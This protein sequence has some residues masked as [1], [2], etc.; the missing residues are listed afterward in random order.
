M[1]KRT[2][3]LLLSFA[4][5]ICGLPMALSG[6]C[7]DQNQ[8]LDFGG[9]S[10]SVEISKA[11]DADN[12]GYS[13]DLELYSPSGGSFTFKALAL[14][15]K[16]IG[17]KI[18]ESQIDISMYGSSIEPGTS[19]EVEI[20]IAALTT[21]GNY[22]GKF[23]IY[24]ID[25]Q[26]TSD[27]KTPICTWEVPIAVRLFEQAKVAIKNTGA[28][29]VN[30]VPK[31]WLNF[32]LPTSIKGEGFTVNVKNEGM[33][34]VE[35]EDYSLFLQG[36]Q[37]SNSLGDEQLYLDTAE[38]VTKILPGRT[39]KLAF[40]FNKKSKVEIDTYSGDVNLH[41]K[42]RG[43]TI[44]T[45]V[46]INRR[47]GVAWALFALFLGIF[48][49][50][51]IKDV[52]KEESQEQIRLIEQFIPMR[53][54]VANI[55]DK[56]AKSKLLVQLRDLESQIN[57]VG[58]NADA[59]AKV[60]TQLPVLSKRVNQIVEWEGLWFRV[61]ENMKNANVKSSSAI[62][63]NMLEEINQVR[64]LILAGKDEEVKVGLG[65][66]QSLMGA[67]QAK[68]TKS[69]SLSPIEEGG[70][71][72]A[73]PKESPGILLSIE[74]L[75]MSIDDKIKE[76]GSAAAPSKPTFWQKVEDFF[77][78][79]MNFLTG[80]RVNARVRYALFRPLAMLVAFTVLLLMGFQ[81]I[82]VNGAAD[83]GVAGIYDY[84]K[85]FLWGVVS[86]VFSR[87]FLGTGQMDV[88]KG[89]APS[90]GA[91]VNADSSDD[92]APEGF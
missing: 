24:Q 58:N 36:S 61:E 32:I 16:D 91:N 66:V 39:E 86:D 44:S 79:A 85:L 73:P 83:F 30:T 26:D 1:I 90:F 43:E 47:M 67:I 13:Y 81:E 12:S 64:D 11:W 65:K 69:R 21:P 41:L 55:E 34:T 50:R 89:A 22:E 35:I 82:Y 9:K 63:G 57:Q 71:A 25:P 10:P 17:E 75:N 54:Q 5:L 20:K 6:Q 33:T 48:V 74:E 37:N 14:R 45:P 60:E 59:K 23:Y 31:S 92:D 70:E 49:G 68:T 76:T 7:P 62:A 4:V 27:S 56:V 8:V 29:T 77:F 19:E 78:K 42:G 15:D 88:I 51:M 2:H 28:I 80:F 3:H 53:A 46:S 38:S 87:S 40:E 18:D 72:I 52:N 84:L